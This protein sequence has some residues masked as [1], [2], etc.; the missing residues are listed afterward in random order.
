M[1]SATDVA[2]AGDS[3]QYGKFSHVWHHGRFSLGI[4]PLTAVEWQ[5][6]N[7]EYL[8]LNLMKEN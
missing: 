5:F 4:Q 7:P 3:I 2:A 1:T 8:G 6:L